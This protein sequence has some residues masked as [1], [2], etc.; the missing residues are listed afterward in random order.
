MG[1]S[2]TSHVLSICIYMHLFNNYL[3]FYVSILFTAI[4]F[5]NIALRHPVTKAQGNNQSILMDVCVNNG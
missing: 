3:N 2:I 4:Y 5:F 1:M